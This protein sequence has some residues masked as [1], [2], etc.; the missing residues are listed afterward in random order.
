MWTL[1][2]MHLIKL[3]LWKK[4]SQKIFKCWLYYFV[5][6]QVFLENALLNIKLKK[7]VPDFNLK[8]IKS[9]KFRLDIQLSF[10]S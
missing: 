1:I 3:A 10:S 6:L 8:V 7:H 2:A 9:D 4:E 5:S